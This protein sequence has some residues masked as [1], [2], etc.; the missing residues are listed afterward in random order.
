M[1]KRLPGDDG[2]VALL[3]EAVASGDATVL[4][5]PTLRTASEE[6]NDPFERD[7]TTEKGEGDRLRRFGNYELLSEIARGGMGVV[8]QARQIG[9]NRLVAL[10]MILAYDIGLSSLSW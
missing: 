1:L 10:K 6:T 9:L 3:R 2:Y 7:R 4:I 8:Y 5:S